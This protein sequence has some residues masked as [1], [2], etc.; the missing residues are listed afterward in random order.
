MSPTSKP[1]VRFRMRYPNRTMPW[2][3][4][5]S[6]ERFAI[7]PEPNTQLGFMEQWQATTHMFYWPVAGREVRHA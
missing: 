1:F 4:S 7:A 3:S 5:R 2:L 6:V